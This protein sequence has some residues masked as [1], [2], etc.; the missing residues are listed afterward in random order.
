[1]KKYIISTSLYSV[2]LLSLYFLYNYLS[3]FLFNILNYNFFNYSNLIFYGLL[4]IFLLLFS[5]GTYFSRDI[6]N[7]KFFLIYGIII[8]SISS[9]FY[10]N[11]INIYTAISLYFILLYFDKEYNPITNLLY[12]FVIF[13]F[14][15]ES[16]TFTYP[17][18]FLINRGVNNLYYSNLNN[19]E[20]FFINGFYNS[21]LEG[22]QSAEYILNQNKDYNGLKLLLL[23]QDNASNDY[24]NYIL[25]TVNNET[26]GL[27]NT[28]NSSI[29]QLIYTFDPEIAIV[30]ALF[31]FEAFYIFLSIQRKIKDL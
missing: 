23:Y 31:I 5:F 8:I 20:Q 14:T 4:L 10:R 28:I 1:M 2:S 9:L 12:I 24:Y 6:K 17:I 3:T 27:N 11:L 25:T 30:S 29:N 18:K 16:Q 22:Y 13:L 26:S 7:K 21:Y 15:F 19:T